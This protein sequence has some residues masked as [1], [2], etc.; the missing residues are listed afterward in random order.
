MVACF[1]SSFFFFKCPIL[2]IFVTA[3]GRKW[4]QEKRPVDVVN[5]LMLWT[6]L[7]C[8]PVYVVNLFML[9]TCLCCEPVD[10]VN[11]LM[12]WTCLCCEP[13]YVMNLF[14]LWTCW[15]YEPVDVMNLFMLWTCLCYEP[16]YVMNPL[17][18]AFGFIHFH[19]SGISNWTKPRALVQ[20][21]HTRELFS[22]QN[23]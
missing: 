11:L 5:L 7:C 14:M 15:C 9:W 19:E 22:A 13:V 1:F 2:H 6:C 8:E 12:L 18:V 4:Q 21:Q 17:P 3:F 23:R 10:A 16:V 20:N